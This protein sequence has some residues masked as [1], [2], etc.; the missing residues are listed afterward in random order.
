MGATYADGS[1]PTLG[2]SWAEFSGS[3]P[4]LRF[5]WDKGIHTVP[6]VMQ[7][8]AEVIGQPSDTGTLVGNAFS[9]AGIAAQ[10][11][12]DA[13]GETLSDVGAAVPTI[14]KWAVIG[15]VAYAVIEASKTA[16]GR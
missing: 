10:N 15:L 9:D 8:E 16:R 4:E 5:S 3:F 12:I 14:A 11:A 6:G 1:S 2:T 7:R 13:V